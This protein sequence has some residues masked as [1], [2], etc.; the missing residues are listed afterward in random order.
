MNLRNLSI[1][2]RSIQRSS[3]ETGSASA[4]IPPAKLPQRHVEAPHPL[5]VP[6]PAKISLK[7]VARNYQRQQGGRVDA[8]EDINLEVGAG[9]FLCVVGPSGCGKSTLL[10]LIAGLDKPSGGDIL[11]SGRP[12]NGPGPDR[13]LIFQDLGLFPW[14]TVRD[15]VEFGLKMKRTDKIALRSIS[16]HY[17]DLVGL[18]QFGDSYIHQLS[19]GMRQRVALARSLAIGPDVLLMDEPFAALDA[20]TRD[21]LHDELERIWKETRQTIIFVTHNVREAAR[22][23]DRV[24]VLT[25]RPG[26]I[27]AEIRI[28]LPRPRRM[29]NA[30]V[31]RFA[32]EVMDNLKE[33]IHRSVESEYRK[34]PVVSAIPAV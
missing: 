32:S 12:V 6:S 33:E 11:L 3:A 17:L 31:A 14:L 10:H 18:S 20:Q 13:I 30:N 29:E 7:N 24:V 8:L 26:R 16:K 4:V 23:G 22:L 19:G 9:E 27:K 34:E 15:N 21:L 25:F 28:D 2:F 5:A 1:S